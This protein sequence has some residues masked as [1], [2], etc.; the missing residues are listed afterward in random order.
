ML[1]KPDNKSLITLTMMFL[2]G[3]AMIFIPLIQQRQEIES[4]TAFMP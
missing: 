2:I 3:I 1:K 4:D